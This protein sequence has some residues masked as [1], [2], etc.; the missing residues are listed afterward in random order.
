[1]FQHTQLR[2]NAED[3]VFHSSDDASPAVENSHRLS[4]ILLRLVSEISGIGT[5]I[6]KSVLVWRVINCF[7]VMPEQVYEGTGNCEF[8]CYNELM[9][10]HTSPFS[11]P[12][13]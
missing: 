11:F 9:T 6:T 4:A 1:V 7:A 12:E 13:F 5:S 2:F 10:H 8:D 3:Q